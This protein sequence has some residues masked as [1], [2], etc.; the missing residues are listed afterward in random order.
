MSQD[1]GYDEQDT[2]RIWFSGQDPSSPAGARKI[3]AFGHHFVKGK[4]CFRG[5]GSIFFVCDACILIR[6]IVWSRLGIRETQG[7]GNFWRFVA[8]Y[9]II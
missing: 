9:A 6:A 2:I 7:C 3:L 4:Q 8:F 5:I 1:F